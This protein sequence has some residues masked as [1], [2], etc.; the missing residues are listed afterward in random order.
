MTTCSYCA[1]ASSLLK[2]KQDFPQTVFPTVWE[3]VERTIHDGRL[4]APEE[5]FREIER[6]NE[7]EAWA[8]LRKLMFKKITVEVWEAA[9][10]IAARFPGLAKHG[11]FGPAADPFVVALARIENHPTNASLYDESGECVVVTE[12]GG[13][14]EQIPAACAAFGVPCTNLVGLFERENWVFR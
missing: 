6:D 12:E 2:M 3:K 14:S 9:Q 10:E 5:V 13:G 11:R 4:F 7:L 8:K 1:D